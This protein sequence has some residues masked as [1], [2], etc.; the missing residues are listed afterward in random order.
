MPTKVI[1]G[2]AWHETGN[3]KSPVFKQNK[4]LFGMRQA[5]KRK[6]FAT[7]ENLLHATYGNIKDSVR[8]YFLRQKDFRIPNSDI[9]E[10]VDATVK[11]GYAEDPLYLSKWLNIINKIKHPTSTMF[12]LTGLF[13]WEY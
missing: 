5:K 8:D 3:F 2:Q 6:N 13:F 7:G 1:Y 11:S 9:S 12:A 10:Y 4:N